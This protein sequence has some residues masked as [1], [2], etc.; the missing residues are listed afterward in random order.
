MA[1]AVTPMVLECRPSKI[2]VCN[3]QSVTRSSINRPEVSGPRF[4]PH[5]RHAAPRLHPHGHARLRPS[6]PRQH[7]ADEPSFWRCLRRVP[8]TGQ[9]DALLARIVTTR[10]H[11]LRPPVSSTSME[12]QPPPPADTTHC[13][14]VL[15]ASPP[16]IAARIPVRASPSPG[17]TIS[18]YS[19]YILSTSPICMSVCPVAGT[20]RKQRQRWFVCYVLPWQ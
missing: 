5:A 8:E 7:I 11:T 19:L 4:T 13:T 12:P 10:K 6:L 15:P 2:V 9:T 20:L 1:V 14:S 3:S 18:T 17:D 16:L